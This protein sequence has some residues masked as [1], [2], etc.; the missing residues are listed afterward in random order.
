MRTPAPTPRKPVAGYE[1]LS[2]VLDRAYL[3]AAVGKGHARHANGKPF[4]RQPLQD[5]VRLHG[6]GFATG[7][8][9]KKA[10]EALG[11]PTKEAQVAELLGAIV[12]LAG[13]VI[14]LEAPTGEA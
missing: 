8:A 12:Y 10:S 11:L 9:G 2:D 7:Q 6:L 4:H 13:A 14:A 3:Q 5:L 1:S